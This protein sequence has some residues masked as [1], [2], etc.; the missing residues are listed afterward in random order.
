MTRLSSA[1]RRYTA[2]AIALH[3]AIAAGILFNLATGFFMESWPP[4]VKAIWVPLHISSGISV[5]ALTVLRIFWRLTHKPPHLAADLAAWEETLAHLVH[6]LLY[7]LMLVLP[8]TGWAL[9]SAH[10]PK[11]GPGGPMLWGLIKLPPIYWIQHSALSAMKAT[12]DKFVQ[13]HSIG[14]WTML[15][16][17]AL[18][19]AGALKHQ[20]ID[21]HAELGRMGIGRV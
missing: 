19:V 20:W 2:V 14:G 13:L 17:L 8:L 12:H 16:A 4:A 10:P 3:W 18:H 1:N 21:G 6:V 11:P 15:G 7:A 5:L 9:I